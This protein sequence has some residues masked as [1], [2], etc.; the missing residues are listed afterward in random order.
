MSCVNAIFECQTKSKCLKKENAIIIE[1]NFFLSRKGEGVYRVFSMYSG[2][3]N[4]W[5][6]MFC[7]MCCFSYGNLK[8]QILITKIRNTDQLIYY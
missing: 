8:L 4:V 6:C 1:Y 2:L 7:L 3:F 5:F